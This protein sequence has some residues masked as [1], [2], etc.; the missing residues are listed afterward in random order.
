MPQPYYYPVDVAD[1]TE[2]MTGAARA[3]SSIMAVRQQ[4]QAMQDTEAQKIALAEQQRQMQRDLSALSAAPTVEGIAQA[5]VKY[6]QL[7][8]QFK[9][10]S[11]VFGPEEQRKR[12]KASSDIFAAY[13]QGHYEQAANI[14]DDYGDAADAQGNPGE[15]K[16]FR[17]MSRVI[18]LD[19]KQ[20]AAPLGMMLH[21]H[22]GN[23]TFLKTYSELQKKPLEVEKA[24][25]EASK[26]GT[27][28]KYAESKAQ[29]EIA[30][31][32][33]QTASLG[34]QAEIAKETN[35]INAMKAQ[36]E[37]TTDAL[38]KKE[39]DLKIAEAEQKRDDM[40]RTK[41]ADFQSAQSQIDNMVNT[42]DKIQN[43]SSDVLRAATG[44]VMQ[45]I[46]TIRDRTADFE[47]LVTLAKDQSFM[48]QIPYMKGLGALSDAE[49]RALKNSL[50]N[51]SLRQSSGQFMASVKEASRLLL[52]ARSYLA[53]RYGL[54]S[55]PVDTP[56]VAPKPEEI[57]A[58]MRKYGGTK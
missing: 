46:P 33:A 4:K 42:L 51:L 2:M 5:M 24:T 35:R 13:T 23:D 48:A 40:V 49:G 3:A 21:A 58:L 37:K 6:P 1:P 57:D 36:A 55:S 17:D 29:A 15:A 39:L 22:V 52:K 18:R 38:K 9:K 44:P 26:A 54:P 53:E 7:A 56:A 28:A 14:A 11:D 19:P 43:V 8:E 30:H 34:A 27:E 10:V 41:R 25:A 12:M 50:Q 45:Y 20:V 16:S 31:T 32:Q 47:E